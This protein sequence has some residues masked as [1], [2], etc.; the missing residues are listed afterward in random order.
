MK[1]IQMITLVLVLA[2]G[3]NWTLLGLMDVDLISSIFGGGMV[4]TVMYLVVTA[5][6]FYHLVPKMIEHLQSA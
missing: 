6:T 4:S 3:L 1:I 5:A 2:G